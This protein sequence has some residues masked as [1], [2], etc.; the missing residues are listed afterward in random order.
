MEKIGPNFNIKAIT[1]KKE[2]QK[3]EHV[4]TATVTKKMNI[5]TYGVN[6]L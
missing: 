3:H 2:K 4:N 5:M 1:L 6:T